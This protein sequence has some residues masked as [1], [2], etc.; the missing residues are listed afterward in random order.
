MGEHK[1]LNAWGEPVEPEDPEDLFHVPVEERKDV[2][3]GDDSDALDDVTGDD[4]DGWHR[5]VPSRD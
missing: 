3:E 1:K 2:D 4:M 5:D